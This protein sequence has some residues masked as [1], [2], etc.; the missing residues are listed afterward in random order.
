MILW[1][2]S[3]RKRIAGH[4]L[5]VDRP[6]IV[7]VCVF[8]AVMV[9]TR[10]FLHT[11][12][13]WDATHLSTLYPTHRATQ[14]ANQQVPLPR[15]IRAVAFTNSGTPSISS[16]NTSFL[17]VSTPS[18]KRAPLSS[19]SEGSLPAISSTGA[20]LA[21]CEQT[22]ISPRCHHQACSSS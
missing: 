15:P 6:G 19:Q 11:Y 2:S 22:W 17:H 3:E 4:Q 13:S 20:L 5:N 7:V 14:A 21:R 18:I 8:A 12:S 10:A 1:S 9:S 16:N